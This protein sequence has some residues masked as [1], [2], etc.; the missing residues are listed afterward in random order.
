MTAEFQHI[1]NTLNALV[2]FEVDKS[3][4]DDDFIA[5]IDAI[6]LLCNIYD[7][8]GLDR[9]E[10]R[11]KMDAHFPQ[12]SRRVY[13]KGNIQATMPLIKALYRYIYGRG[14]DNADRGPINRR[15]SFIEMCRKAVAA[16][17]DK[18]MMHSTDYLYVLGIVSR[19]RDDFDCSASKEYSASVNAYLKDLDNV[20]NEEKIR[21]LKAYQDSVG[22][23]A[24]DDCDKW[25]ET[26]E[27]LRLI[28]FKPLDD[29]TFL[30]WC[31][32]TNQTPLTELKR[33]SEHSKRVQV[34]YLQALTAS[35]FEKQR[36]LN[37]KRKLNRDLKTLNDNIIGDIIDIKI[38][39]DMSVSTL[40]ALETIFYLRLQ[41]AQVSW[42]ENEPIYESLCRDRFEQLANAL[43]KK[44]QTAKYLNEKIEILERIEVINL[45]LHSDHS[46]F[47]LEEASSLEDLPDLNYAQRL[48]LKWLPALTPEDDSRIVAE[49]LPQTNSS[50]E[51]ATLA[52]ISD[53]CTDEERAAII[54]R[55]T[56]LVNG[57]TASNDTA[58][59]GNLLALAAYWNSNPGVRQR[60]TDV[61]NKAVATETLS[62]PEK[63]INAIA[64]AIYVQIDTLAGKYAFASEI[65]T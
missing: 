44:Y 24:S 12:F 45:T 41:L 7:E 60:L 18:P 23:A 13:S 55:Y 11:K 28:D 14:A 17:K 50:F 56:V 57:A 62:L 63:R 64:A 22:H 31:D 1:I 27:C 48:R 4:S 33:R 26:R 16:Y 53:F 49:L 51:M 5:N 40:Y 43:T 8:L 15:N 47:A 20:S 38:D 34:E 10:I 61:A 46:R 39:S 54:D 6:N 52:L 30:I 36:R 19:M 2:R 25:I 65:P 9:T 35:E 58:E 29:D 32:V 37:V 3:M 21:R 59:L 42:T